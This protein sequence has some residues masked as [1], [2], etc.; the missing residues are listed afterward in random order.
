MVPEQYKYYRPNENT[1]EL[2]VLAD[3]GLFY[4]VF[5]LL[6]KRGNY[7]LPVAYGLLPNKSRESCERFFTLLKGAWPQ[8]NPVT[9]SL[10]FEQATLTAVRNA[11]PGAALL[12]CLY[13]L[14]KNVRLHVSREGI[15]AEKAL[16]SV[17]ARTV[18]H[19]D[20]T[21]NHA[22]AA[23]RK[24]QAMLQMDHPGLWKFIDALMHVQKETDCRFEQY[25]RGD[26]NVPKRK[27]Y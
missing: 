21:N 2:F 15:L 10:D 14:A 6:A 13:H 23:H 12:G 24:L 7:V 20:R 1:R 8:L 26:D 18:N 27:K 3:S 17:H 5:V 16:W 22:E 19:L 9:V 4:Q 25:V 11:F